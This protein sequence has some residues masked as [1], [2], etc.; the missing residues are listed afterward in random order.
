MLER[1]LKPHESGEDLRVF[2]ITPHY[3][4][5]MRARAREWS[6]DFIKYQIECFRFTIKDYPEVLEILEGELH[7]RELNAIQRS[8]RRMSVAEIKK[9]LQQF[10]DRPDHA[11]VLRTE[12]EIRSGASRLRDDEEGTAR[13]APPSQ[14]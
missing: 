2:Y 9:Q 10:S 11:E 12:L 1:S 3:L 13:I 7:R 8:V 5:Q 6:P 4:A 14:N